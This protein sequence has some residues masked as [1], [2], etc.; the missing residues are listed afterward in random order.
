MSRRIISLLALLTARSFI[1][2]MARYNFRS[3]NSTLALIS[4]A[5]CSAIDL[6]VTVLAISP[7]ENAS[8]LSIASVCAVA[9]GLFVTIGFTAGVFVIDIFDANCLANSNFSDNVFS[10]VGING[11]MIVFFFG[12]NIF[13][14][15]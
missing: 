5:R 10:P 15:S 7:N 6:A 14:I 3:P 8:P 2:S 12:A 11:C 9:D 4:S 13:S 1:P